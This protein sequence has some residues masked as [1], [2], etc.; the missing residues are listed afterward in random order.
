M[1]YPIQAEHSA[2]KK[3]KAPSD[4]LGGLE[5]ALQKRGHRLGLEGR[6]KALEESI[7]DE[8]VQTKSVAWAGEEGGEGEGWN[9]SAVSEGL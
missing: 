9:V 7:G 1:F 8:Q 2:Q 4:S 3:K 6:Q 5:G